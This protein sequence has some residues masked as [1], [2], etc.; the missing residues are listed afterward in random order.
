MTREENKNSYIHGI[1]SFMESLLFRKNGIPDDTLQVEINLSRERKFSYETKNSNAQCFAG[2]RDNVITNRRTNAITQA[3]ASV[4]VCA[5]PY[6][7]KEKDIYKKNR[8]RERNTH[9]QVSSF[10]KLFYEHFL[11]IGESLCTAIISVH[12]CKITIMSSNES[13]QFANNAFQKGKER[14]NVGRFLSMHTYIQYP[15]KAYPLRN[16]SGHATTSG[17]PQR[18]HE[19]HATIAAYPPRERRGHATKAVYPPRERKGHATM[20]AC[21]QRIQSGHATMAACPLRAQSGHATMAAC[22][23]RTQSGHATMEACPL[24][25]QRGYDHKESCPPRYCGEHAA[26]KDG[27][28]ECNTY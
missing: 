8:L 18:E 10:I 4:C 13:S 5:V 2:L 15:S 22:P 16:R 14:Y 6:E 19:G 20:A 25:T 21:P 11:K 28:G 17:Y 9:T 27:K 23:L 3:R 1:V 12:S 24:Q 7:K 26:L